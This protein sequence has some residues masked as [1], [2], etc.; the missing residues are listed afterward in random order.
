[1]AHAVRVGDDEPVA[2]EADEQLAVDADRDR[3]LP[4]ALPHHDEVVDAKVRLL[5][6][7]L[8]PQRGQAALLLVGLLLVTLGLVLRR[9]ADGKS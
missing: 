2:G 5:A 1:M 6:V 7:G 8:D 3:D 9:R 4:G